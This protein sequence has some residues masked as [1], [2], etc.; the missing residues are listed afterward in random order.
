LTLRAAAIDRSKAAP[1]KAHEEV[2]DTIWMGAADASGLVVSYIQSLYWEFGS[3]VGAAAD[4]H[5]DARNR[6]L[7]FSLDR[8]ALNV[9]EPGRQPLHTLCAALAVLR[10]AA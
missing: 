2:G 9:L 7:S 6:G 5:R 8:S 4:R 1:W 10:D 3:G